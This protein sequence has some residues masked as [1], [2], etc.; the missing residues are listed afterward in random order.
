MTITVSKQ[1]EVTR[2]DVVAILSEIDCRRWYCTI[3]YSD[4]AYKYAR[5]KLKDPE[6]EEVLAQML[7]DGNKL[8]FVDSEDVD[9]RYALSLP[10]LYD[11]I[12]QA[13]EE[14]YYPEYHWYV[15]DKLDPCKIDSDVTDVI[16]QFALFGEVMFG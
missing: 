14:E 1:Y 2:E 5:D 6:Y 16:L 4:L 3:V 7:F 13:I 11:G 8:K 15:D 9:D 12:R 10:M